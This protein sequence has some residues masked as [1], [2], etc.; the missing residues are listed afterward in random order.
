ML[1]ILGDWHFLSL[2]WEL[3]DSCFG[4]VVACV[5]GVFRIR[6]FVCMYDDCVYFLVLGF[7]LVLLCCLDVRVGCVSVLVF[8]GTGRK[9]LRTVFSVVLGRV[10]FRE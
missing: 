5:S 2:L 8:C 7:V 10:G 9:Y 4:G 3:C 6:N 1:I